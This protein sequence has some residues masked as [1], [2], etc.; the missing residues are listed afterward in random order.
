MSN[1]KPISE[2]LSKVLKTHL[3]IILYREI[4][5]ETGYSYSSVC[6]I[7]DR[8]QKVNDKNRVVVHALIEKCFDIIKGGY[9]SDLNTLFTSAPG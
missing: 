5:H 1:N 9:K 4:G 3:S 7:V 8:R 6:N 2:D